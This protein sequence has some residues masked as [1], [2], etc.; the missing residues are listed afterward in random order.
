MAKRGTQYHDMLEKQIY[1]KEPEP[2]AEHHELVPQRILDD[3]KLLM[4]CKDHAQWFSYEI[5]QP[6]KELGE[7]NRR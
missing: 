6:V 2:Q 5:V 3:G 1:S 4:K 7:R